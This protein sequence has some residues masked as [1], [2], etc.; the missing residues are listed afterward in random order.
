[1]Y[2]KRKAG[3]IMQTSLQGIANRAAKE[4]KH[5]FGNLY[6]LLNEGNLRWCFY[7]LKRGAA[8]GVDEVDWYE[9][10]KNLDAN[11]HDLVKRLK[12]KRYRAR[13]IRRR[14]IPKSEAGKVRP[15]GI[16]VIEDKLLQL[17]VAKILSAIY[18]QDFLECSYGYREGLGPR[19]AVQ[20]LTLNL[21]YGKFTWIVDADV[22]G[23]FDNIDHDWMI[24]MIKERVHDRAFTNLIRKWLKAGILETDSQVLHPATGTPQ[25]GIVSPVLANIYLHYV[26]DL[27]FE[28]KVKPKCKGKVKIIRYADD[29]V[30]AFQYKAEADRF[31]KDLAERLA[32]FGLELAKEKSRNLMFSRFK[33]DKN[34][35]F[36][37]LGFEFRWRNDRG[38]QPRMTRRTSRK[39]LRASIA[40]FTT[41]IKENRH[42]RTRWVME[43][44]VSKYRGYWNYYGIKGNYNSLRLFYYLS[45]R[46]L[47]KWLNRRGG[48][49]SYN[50]KGF[51]ELFKY[52]SIPEPRITEKGMNRTYKFA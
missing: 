5:R 2:R 8:P 47:F 46:I 39:K 10:E 25:G 4:R 34:E 7:R 31:Y 48:R 49:H 45:R 18:E 29:F 27:W 14:Y 19:D 17:G 3:I 28:K 22:K 35:G 20:D 50:W 1:M 38:G 33:T 11:I 21:Q 41:W 51:T 32:K 6:G 12:R 43:I 16:P 24:R 30:C 26:L 37:F 52:Y 44:L 40:N 36:D 13:L 9:Y 15:L 23:F 42:K